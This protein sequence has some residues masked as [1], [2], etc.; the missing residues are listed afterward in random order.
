MMESNYLQGYKEYS[1]KVFKQANAASKIWGE[2]AG[3]I[4][5]A[6]EFSRYV[7]LR[8]NPE[9]VKAISTFD[10]MAM[11]GNKVPVVNDAKRKK[12]VFKDGRLYK[13][14]EE[15]YALYQSTE[16]PLDLV[17]TE[18]SKLG[19]SIAGGDKDEE[20]FGIQA[21]HIQNWSNNNAIREYLN[22]KTLQYITTEFVLFNNAIKN[23]LTDKE[24]TEGIGIAENAISKKKI[25]D[26]LAYDENGDLVFIELKTEKNKSDDPINQVAM[27]MDYYSIPEVK[28][29]FI[30]LLNAYPIHPLQPKK[31]AE[32]LNFRGLV[33]YGYGETIDQEKT[34]C[35]PDPSGT[36]PDIPVIRFK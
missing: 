20:E 18:M 8:P 21:K 10:H 30:K 19:F 6:E 5:D 16:K 27:Y 7:H 11:R 31:P 36:R 14:L 3:V 33:V 35:K 13:L 1:D 34:I 24:K 26:I 23:F 4:D 15:L 28:E 2:F 22:L 29:S 32:K 25:V 17:Q 9:N 12:K